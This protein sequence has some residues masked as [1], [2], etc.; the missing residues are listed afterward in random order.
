MKNQTIKAPTKMGMMVTITTLKAAI[1]LDY[2]S[3]QR[4]FKNLRDCGALKIDIKLNSTHE[5]LKA[6][7]LELIAGLSAIVKTE[8]A[9]TANQEKFE[10]IAAKLPKGTIV[11]NCDFSDRLTS[12]DQYEQKWLAFKDT[13]QAG[14]AMILMGDFYETFAG[15]AIRLAIALELVVT[16]RKGIAMCGVPVHAIE[17]YQATLRQAGIALNIG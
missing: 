13:Q 15:D 17:R 11:N 8:S 9:T 2:R 5:V 6:Y 7:A 4:A 10:A 16:T 1:E 3:L 12:G 14:I